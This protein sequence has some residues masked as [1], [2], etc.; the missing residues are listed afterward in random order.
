MLYPFRKKPRFDPGLFLIEQVEICRW[1]H[2][3]KAPKTIPVRRADFVVAD[4]LELA[5]AEMEIT[6]VGDLLTKWNTALQGNRLE[7]ADD[8]YALFKQ[9]LVSL[10]HFAC[11]QS[12]D[13]DIERIMVQAIIY[14]TKVNGEM[15]G[16]D[17]QAGAANRSDEGNGGGRDRG[18]LRQLP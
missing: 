10:L 12:F 17:R 1:V 2:R 4:R 14:V 11:H 7:E 13:D 5:K 8:L 6:K 9:K 3:G 16:R 18:F 15:Y